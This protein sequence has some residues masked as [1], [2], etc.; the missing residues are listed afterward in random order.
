[1]DG[2]K[3]HQIWKF[4]GVTRRLEVLCALMPVTLLVRTIAKSRA[5]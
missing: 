3:W 1:M 5:L 4:T 2:C